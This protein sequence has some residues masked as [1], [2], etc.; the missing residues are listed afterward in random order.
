MPPLSD[1]PAPNEIEVSLFG[2]GVGE[3]C[4]V[5]L[6]DNAWMVV[7]SCIDRT[8][9]ENA[10]TAYFDRMG[11]DM[12]EAVV[13]V[14]ATHAHNDHIG[15]M[16]NIVE[17]S[18]SAKF[19][20]SVAMSKEEFFRLRE[21]DIELEEVRESVMDELR[22]VQAALGDRN[23]SFAIAGLDLLRKAA[24]PG[25]PV[26]RVTALSP[27]NLEVKKAQEHLAN[28]YPT[29]GSTPKQIRQDPNQMAVAV[30]IEIGDE[31]LLLGSDLPNGPA[32]CGWMAVV[33][34]EYL[35]GGRASVFKVSHHGSPT[36][37]HQRVWDELLTEDVVSVLTP[38][39]AGVHPRPDDDDLDRI[40]EKSGSA[41]VT[42]RT[43]QPKP[44]AQ[45]RA[46]IGSLTAY[47]QDPRDP[48]GIPGHVRLRK[49]VGAPEGWRV[50]L[51]P[52]AR[53]V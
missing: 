19:A 39:R 12:D 30:W 35:N 51:V 21:I 32:N 13:L 46:K 24:V 20:C 29:A 41:Y 15:K 10:V 37:E 42:A 49:G 33:D 8:T 36:S 34:S 22:R 23:Q 28:A 16:S 14:L 17:R 53:R 47:V 9:Q 18:K 44:S 45:M 2:P 27:S 4:V 31:S 50:D 1:P 26:V 7:D 6:T 5:H 11:I 40:R 3:A 48:D 25:S 38:Y 43:A 52:P